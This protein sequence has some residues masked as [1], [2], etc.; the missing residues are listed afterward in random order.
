[1][2]LGLLSYYLAGVRTAMSYDEGDTAG[3]EELAHQTGMLDDDAVDFTPGAELE[4]E[5]V[6]AIAGIGP[7]TNAAAAGTA[8]DAHPG[9]LRRRFSSSLRRA[10]ER[11][12][13]V[14][15]KRGAVG[16]F[17][18]CFAPSPL[19]TA[20]AYVGGLVRFAFSR[21]LLAS[22]A[23]KYLLAGI[24]VVLGLVFTSAAESVAIPEVHIPVIDVTLFDHGDPGASAQPSSAPVSPP[25]GVSD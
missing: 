8:Q 5:A 3:A 16:M 6:S 12:A 18:L 20:G 4:A 23:A 14:I 9:G 1:M 10:Q 19:S 24:I 22:F 2:G 11:A 25:A 21:Y 17:L 7:T 13:P 15:E